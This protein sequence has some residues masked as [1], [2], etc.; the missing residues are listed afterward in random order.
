MNTVIFEEG[1]SSGFE[2]SIKEGMQKPINHFEKEL[3]SIRTGRASTNLVEDIKADVYGQQMRLKE[4]AGI[5][6]PD[7]RLI[8][9]QP[10]DKSIIGE[11]EKAILASDLGVTPINDGTMIRIQLPQM[12]ES[13]RLELDK[14]LGKKTEECK[15]G[16]RNVRKEFHNQLRDAERKKLIS[17]DFAKRLNDLLQKITDQFIAKTEELHDRKAKEIKFV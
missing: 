1:N 6:T 11:I 17:E 9:I 13:R 10:W 5:A 7:S 2:N 8:T 16:I 15:I 14:V 4:L 3:L 12:T